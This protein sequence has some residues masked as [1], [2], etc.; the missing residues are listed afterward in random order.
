MARTLIDRPDEKWALIKAEDRQN[1]R[2]AIFVHGFTGSYLGTW[3]ALPDFL[4]QNSANIT[5]FEG[6]DFLF[7]GYDTAT[8][9]NFLGIAQI[10]FSKWTLATQSPKID[11]FKSNDYDTLSLIGHS[12][13][14]LGIRQ[15]LCA[16]SMQPKG[17]DKAVKSAVL[18]G[19]P[20]NGSPLANF[21]LGAHVA[22][23]VKNKNLLALNPFAL[24]IAGA[25]KPQSP[26]LI[27]LKA[28]YESIQGHGCF[29]QPALHLHL[30]IGDYVVGWQHSKWGS[31]PNA[32]VHN[33]SHNSLLKIVWKNG[34]PS[35]IIL[36][37]LK[38]ALQ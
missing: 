16:L 21:G 17:F 35:G 30:G 10:I 5:E 12:L 4:I 23:L 7:V 18:L 37:A 3:G 26:E 8:I 1:T 36:G 32:I 19:A 14:T 33:A 2:L 15:T 6:W 22:E 29:G 9:D 13:G 24:R 11:P 34:Q 27:M 38:V 31:E 28:W 20:Q 25:L